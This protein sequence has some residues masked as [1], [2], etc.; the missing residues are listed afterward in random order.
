MEG[1]STKDMYYKAVA[2]VRAQ[3]Q[4]LAQYWGI[5]ILI[6]IKKIFLRI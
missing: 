4:A 5:F 3:G 6:L 2:D 1:K